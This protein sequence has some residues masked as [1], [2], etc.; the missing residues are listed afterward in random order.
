MDAC[1]VCRTADGASYWQVFYGLM[2]VIKEIKNSA[3]EEVLLG[4]LQC[5]LRSHCILTTR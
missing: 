4:R 3:F 2:G 5:K 1:L